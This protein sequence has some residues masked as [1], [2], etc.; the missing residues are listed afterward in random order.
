MITSWGSEVEGFPS[1]WI[2]NGGT[3]KKS[4]GPRDETSLPPGPEFET[5]GSAYDVPVDRVFAVVMPTGHC[6]GF[7]PRSKDSEVVSLERDMSLYTRATRAFW[8]VF[9]AEGREC[10][11]QTTSSINRTLAPERVYGTA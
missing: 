5:R 11:H 1:R 8:K 2:A 10:V 4:P 3:K 7:E 9:L 6:V